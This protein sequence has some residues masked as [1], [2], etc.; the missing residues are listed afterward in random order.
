MTW[1]DTLKLVY[2]IFV[3]IVFVTNVVFFLIVTY[4]YT[5][6][7][8]PVERLLSF[9]AVMLIDLY[10]S[11]VYSIFLSK[12]LQLLHVRFCKYEERYGFSV[13][14]KKWVKKLRPILIVGLL[15]TTVFGPLKY[16]MVQNYPVVMNGIYPTFSFTE[17]WKSVGLVITSIGYILVEIQWLTSFVAIP[18]LSLFLWQEFKRVETQF[19]ELANSQ[20]ED[21]EARFNT[22]VI[23][24]GHV[25][26]VLE[27]INNYVQHFIF[28]SV[29]MTLPV[30]CTI[31]YSIFSKS[32]NS[33]EVIFYST[34]C[35]WGL[36]CVGLRLLVDALV[37][38]KA[39]GTL[40][41]VWMLDKE[42]FSGIG[43]QKMNLFVSR[44]TGDTIGYNIHGLFTITMPTL[45]G[46]VGTLVTYII[47]VVQF[48]PT[49]PTCQCGEFR[50]VTQ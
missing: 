32:V 22:L 5:I 19:Q 8:R 18:F 15:F 39:H 25:T 9:C 17:P 13:G 33:E 27:D 48:K 30:T 31:I 12:T 2:V 11:F 10:V 29:F 24:H 26:E 20:C 4:N 37:S 43:L 38:S 23:H 41:Y 42:R 50:N 7:S 36:L 40:Q 46:I 45:L 44:L 35:V 6:D 21:P 16:S 28:T 14:F 49:E 47:V 34:G 1:C 3:Q